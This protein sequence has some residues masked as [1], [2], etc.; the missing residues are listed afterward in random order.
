[1]DI[2]C[3]I[4]KKCFLPEFASETES[5]RL[6][7]L[8]QQIYYAV[9]NSPY[10]RKRLAGLESL[11]SLGELEQIPFLT[12]SELEQHSAELMCVSPSTVKRVV[13]MYSSGT[14]GHFKRLFFT[15]NDLE[16]TVRFFSQGMSWICDEGDRVGIC[17]PG[18]S[19]DGLIDLLSRGLER[20][21]TIPLKIGPVTDLEHSVDICRELMPTVI[22]GLPAQIRLLALRC[23]WLRPSVVLLSGD[24]VSASVRA[25]LQR[26]WGCQ[27]FEHYGLTES[28]LGCAVECP[29]NTGMHIRRDELIIEI[30]DPDTGCVLPNGQFGE[31]VLTTLRREAMPFIRYRTGDVGRLCTGPECCGKVQMLERVIGRLDASVHTGYGKLNMQMLDEAL[32][33]I[34]EVGDFCAQFSMGTLTLSINSIA[35]CSLSR[36]KVS[37]LNALKSYEPLHTALSRVRVDISVSEICTGSAYPNKRSLIV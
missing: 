28:G 26:L 19:S 35:V 15:E 5:H 31:I 11:C 25:T 4:K 8:G 6:E 13:S 2:S 7:M 9:A 36:L 12:S 23:T 34:D 14:T 22:I 20:I 33:G 1:M 3:R 27:V 37:V 24:Y 17:M 29:G 21:D 10:Y 16:R 18:N 32:L 30:I